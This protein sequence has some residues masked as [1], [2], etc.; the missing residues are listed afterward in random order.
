MVSVVLCTHNPRA[1]FFSRTLDSLRAQDLSLSK[2]ELVIVDNHSGKPVRT[3]VDLS[4]HPAARIV[5]ESELG[6]TPARLRGIAETQGDILVFVDDDNVLQPDYLRVAEKI[7][8]QNPSLGCWGGTSFGEFE[9]PPPIWAKPYLCY[10]AIREVTRFTVS[11]EYSFDVVPTGAG[12]CIRRPIAEVYVAQIKGSP[13]RRELDRKGNSLVSGGDSDL[14]FTAIDRG[15]SIGLSP[16]LRLSH[17]M[18]KN[19][20]ELPYLERLLEGIAASAPLVL[21]VRGAYRPRRPAGLFHQFLS[22]YRLARQPKP[23][24]LLEAAR[25]RGF[26]KAEAQ[27]ATLG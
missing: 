4:W 18:S 1:D 26:A 8:I 10:L 14:A 3:Y 9:E 5:D 20:L 25:A 21:Y 11:A 23:I 22:R 24:R 6:L 12:M 2:W 19:R 13:L 16:E 27:I 17:L 7:G 15:L